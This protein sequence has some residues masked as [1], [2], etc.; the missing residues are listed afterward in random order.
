MWLFHHQPLWFPHLPWTRSLG[1]NW[2]GSKKGQI[3]HRNWAERNQRVGI[4]H[5]IV[6]HFPGSKGPQMQSR[7]QAPKTGGIS[8]Q[9]KVIPN[10]WGSQTGLQELTVLSYQAADL[11]QCGEVW[12]CAQGKLPSARS[13]WKAASQVAG[14]A[15]KRLESKAESVLTAQMKPG[16]HCPK[17]LQRSKVWCVQRSWES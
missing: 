16:I 8:G 17:I 14:I 4:N 13:D 15:R 6:E 1:R 2:R 3:L 9:A 7:H 5:Q 10:S 12:S 11:M